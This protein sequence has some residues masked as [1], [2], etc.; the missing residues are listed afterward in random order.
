MASIIESQILQNKLNI[1]W[2]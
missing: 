2:S 1:L